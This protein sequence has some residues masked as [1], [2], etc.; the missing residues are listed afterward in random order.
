MPRERRHRSSEN[1]LPAFGINRYDLDRLE[2]WAKRNLMKFSKGKCKVLH[3][4]RNNP[5]HWDKL[6]AGQLE[7]SSAEK[8]LGVLVDSKLTM[9][10]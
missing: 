2:N 8:D 1:S 7:N 3:L 9:G 6:G 4:G 5:G 10:H